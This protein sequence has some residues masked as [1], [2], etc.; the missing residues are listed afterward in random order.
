MS[1]SGPAGS[2]APAT[3]DERGRATAER[4]READLP[5]DPGAL[6]VVVGDAPLD[7]GAVSV[8]DEGFDGPHAGTAGCLA[9]ALEAVEETGD[10]AVALHYP[11]PAP[12]AAGPW[13]VLTPLGGRL[14]TVSRGRGEL[15]VTVDADGDL[16]RVLGALNAAATP[17]HEHYPVAA[18]ELGVFVRGLTE[19]ERVDVAETPADVAETR[20]DAGTY[21]VTFEVAVTP[22]TTR[23]AVE[24]RFADVEGVVDVVYEE[25]VG[26]ERASL[27]AGFR[28]AVETAAV[29]VVGDAE[30]EWL[31][32]PGVFAGL[33]GDDRVAVGAGLPGSGSFAAADRDATAALL[34]G[35]LANLEGE[36]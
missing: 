4:A 12:T 10:G 27:S 25:T 33:P 21:D 1:G 15:V 19:F 2:A 17:T 18:D 3:L 9:A 16:E 23:A 14:A 32:G 22:A 20:A 24:G 34:A 5:A 11:D 8:T 31:A 36:R 29:D 35:V 7:P 28:T 6:N 26:V 30:Y 13:V